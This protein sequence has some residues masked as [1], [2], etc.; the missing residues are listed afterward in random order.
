[1]YKYWVWPGKK[2]TPISLVK[3]MNPFSDYCFYF[4]I[5]LIFFIL[6]FLNIFIEV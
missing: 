5:F 6:F 3:S 1:M 4:L 2:C